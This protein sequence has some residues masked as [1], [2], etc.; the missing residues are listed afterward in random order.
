MKKIKSGIYG[1]NVLLDG[2]MNTGATTVII[3]SPGAGKTT[4][5]LQF[6]RRG[7]QDGQDCIF[8]SLDESKDQI[9][10][11]SI[12]MG[13]HDI[14][15]YLDER[16]LVFVDASGRDFSRFI[17]EDLS[18]FVDKWAGSDTRIAVDPLTPVLWSIK[19][20]YEQRDKILSLLKLTKKVG[21]VVCTLEEHGRADLT[22][23]ETIIPMYLADCVIHLAYSLRG[24][25]AIRNLRIVKC[26]NSRHSELVHP[27]TIVRGLGIVVG[28][29]PSEKNVQ[30]EKIISTL[31]NT[32]ISGKLRTSQKT[33]QM[34]QNAFAHLKDDDFYGLSSTDVLQSLRDELE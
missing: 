20:H 25:T 32:I 33:R 17:E 30:S 23:G 5:A 22:G 9:I 13:W 3:G 19:D 7:L 4:F 16:K 15:D 10:Q 8:I 28:R 11:E 12:E 18:T 24:N 27:Y 21:T 6:I 34:L 29:T 2:G 14:L 1:L 26:R 31:K